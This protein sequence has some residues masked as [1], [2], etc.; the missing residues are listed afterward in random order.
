MD[1]RSVTAQEGEG[2]ETDGLLCSRN[3][4]P[5]KDGEGATR[6]PLCSQNAHDQNVLV[7]C[8]QLR[9]ALAAP[10]ERYEEDRKALARANGTSRRASVV[11]CKKSGRF[12][13]PA[14]TLTRSS[15]AISRGNLRGHSRFLDASFEQP[16]A[17]I[18]KGLTGLWQDIPRCAIRTENRNSASYAD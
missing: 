14:A 2:M 7:R 13:H 3:A 18:Q 16:P 8:A 15:S 6:C 10:L 12:E 1:Y 4:R 5:K 17:T 9:A 11:G